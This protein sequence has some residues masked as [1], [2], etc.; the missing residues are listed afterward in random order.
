MAGRVMPVVGMGGFGKIFFNC[1][2]RHNL[3]CSDEYLTDIRRDDKSCF[4][5][6]ICNFSTK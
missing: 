2:L 1:L 4:S 3:L 5:E 6:M